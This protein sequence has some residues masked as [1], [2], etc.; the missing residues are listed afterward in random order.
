MKMEM[1]MDGQTLRINASEIHGE[2]YKHVPEKNWYWVKIHFPELKLYV[3]SIR[4]S[5]SIKYPN[6]EMWVQPPKM[7]IYG[8]WITVMEFEN[9]A[10]L[11]QL[12]HDEALRAVDLFQREQL[13][14]D[15]LPIDIDDLRPP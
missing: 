1:K 9:G 3:N 5:P 2:V 6:K 14:P 15:D 8:R 4:V 13:T 10:P 12:I 11:W 7:P